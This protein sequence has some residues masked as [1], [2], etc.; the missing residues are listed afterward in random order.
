MSPRTKWFLV[1]LTLL[2]AAAGAG[3]TLWMIVPPLLAGAIVAPLVGLIFAVVIALYVLGGVAAVRF[4]RDPDKRGMLRFYYAL[5]VVAIASPA[6]ELRFFSG[7]HLLPTFGL[8]K[9]KVD[10]GLDFWFGS[11]WNVRLDGGA[12]W[13]VGVNLVAVL[14]LWLLRTR[15]PSVDAVAVASQTHPNAN[16]TDAAAAPAVPPRDLRL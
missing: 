10:V 2:G 5:Q 11:S 4:A 1:V 12:D 7:A 8:A 3:V 14:V 15:R 9:W 16:P 6:L 13:A